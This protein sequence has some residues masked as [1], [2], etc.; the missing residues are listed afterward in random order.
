M[1]PLSIRVATAIDKS[2]SFLRI[3]QSEGASDRLLFLHPC[4]FQLSGVWHMYHNSCFLQQY[5]ALMFPAGMLKHEFTVKFL[6]NFTQNSRTHP[7]CD[8][9]R[10]ISNAIVN[11]VCIARLGRLKQKFASIHNTILYIRITTIVVVVVTLRWVTSGSWARLAAEFHRLHFG[12]RKVD[13]I[14]FE[15]LKAHICACERSEMI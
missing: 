11:F 14:D 13:C 1:D 9:R 12:R 6:F 7:I 15:V 10:S 5:E 3:L 4:W 2:E 8:E